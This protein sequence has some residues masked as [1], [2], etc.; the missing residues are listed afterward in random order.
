VLVAHKA[1]DVRHGEEQ[2]L[3]DLLEKELITFTNLLED[4][5]E[6]GDLIIDRNTV[7]LGVSNRTNQ[8]AIQHLQSL[9]P[10]FEVM[11]IPFTDKAK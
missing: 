7:Y 11:T 8:T 10:A 1:H 3:I 9:L 4:K 5:I 6:G 2:L